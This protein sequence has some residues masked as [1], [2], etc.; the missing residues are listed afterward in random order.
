MQQRVILFCHPVAGQSLGKQHGK[1]GFLLCIQPKNLALK[2]FH[3]PAFAFK[4]DDADIGGNGIVARQIVKFI[5]LMEGHLPAFQDKPVLIRG[6]DHLSLV[7]I[8]HFPE[9][10]ALT[11]II[12][13]L[14]KLHIKQSNDLLDIKNPLKPDTCNFIFHAITSLSDFTLIITDFTLHC[15]PFTIII[16]KEGTKEYDDIH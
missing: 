4:G 6:A 8:D 2:V 16:K 9:I 15:N 11:V 3:G 14:G 7:D 1:Q 13:V 10:M 12:K 5:G